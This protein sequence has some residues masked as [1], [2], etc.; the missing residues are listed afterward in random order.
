[1]TFN[2]KLA[3]EYARGYDAGKQTAA[4]RIAELEEENRMGDNANRLLWDR[5]AE[6]EK[7]INKYLDL[8]IGPDVA[9]RQILHEAVGRP[10]P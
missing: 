3:A 8:P 10:W 2:A 1:M 9:G 4:K 6:L 7:L 5:V